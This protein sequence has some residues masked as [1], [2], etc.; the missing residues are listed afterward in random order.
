MKGWLIKGILMERKCRVQ[1]SPLGIRKWSGEFSSAFPLW[2]R[3]TSVSLWKAADQAFCLLVVSVSPQ[4]HLHQDSGTT[5]IPSPHLYKFSTILHGC[6][7][8]I[9][10]LFFGSVSV[11]Y[12]RSNALTITDTSVVKNNK[13]LLLCTS[14]GLLAG[15]AG[16]ELSWAQSCRTHVCFCGHK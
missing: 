16:L 10:R 8:R 6:H 9:S 11:T 7:L 15:L 1:P 3:L 5:P 13:H 12:Y 2:C 14:C 4:C